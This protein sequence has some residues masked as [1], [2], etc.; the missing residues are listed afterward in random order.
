MH[1]LSKINKH[2]VNGFPKLRPILSAINTG[3]YKWGKCFVPLPK[4][5]TSSNYTVK[6][7]CH[8]ARDITQ[9]SS[10]LFMASLDVDSFFTNLPLD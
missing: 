3:T 5:F 9:E 8:F 4:P 2:L 6:D 7:S 1:G 10:K